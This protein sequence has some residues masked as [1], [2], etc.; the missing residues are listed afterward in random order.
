LAPAAPLQAA[1]A[2]VHAE[3]RAELKAIPQAPAVNAPSG[4]ERVVV[5]GQAAQP[6]R[7]RGYVALTTSWTIIPLDAARA[8]LGVKPVTIP[9]LPV[10]AVRRSPSGDGVILVE[11]AV[12]QAAVVQLFQRRADESEGNLRSGVVS[13]S[14]AARDYAAAAKAQGGE[15]LARYVGSLRVEIAGPLSTDSLSKLLEL[16]K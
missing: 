7:V 9:G 13:D 4:M 10:R 12:D 8:T 3:S 11:Q 15:R 2:V 1:P 16:V 5:T 14:L 6:V